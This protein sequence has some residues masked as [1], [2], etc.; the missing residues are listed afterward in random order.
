MNFPMDALHRK[1]LALAAML[2]AG[3][4]VDNIARHGRCDI[5]DLSPLVDSI[6]ARESDNMLQIYGSLNRLAVGLHLVQELLSG[7]KAELARRL[8]R[9]TA[10]MI[11]LEK[12]LARDQPMLERLAEEMQRIRRQAEYF[13]QSTHENVLASLAA[14]YGETLS[15]LRPR[16]I[17][18]GKAEHLR[19]KSNTNMIRVALL[20]GIRAAHLWRHAGGHPLFLIF[21]RRALLRACNELLEHRDQA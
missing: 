16:I 17:V 15:T 5:E 2:Q 9:Y 3:R 10:G 1:A 21:R 14:L 7:H 12:K 4:I 8:M 20:A 13:G 18:H 6:L 19:Q 11:T